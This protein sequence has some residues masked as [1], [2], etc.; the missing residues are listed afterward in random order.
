MRELGKNPQRNYTDYP[1]NAWECDEEF[2][3]NADIR[4]ER[5]LAHL[6]LIK[7]RINDSARKGPKKTIR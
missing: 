4:F 1:E 2:G 6:Q 5:K 3:V 7:E